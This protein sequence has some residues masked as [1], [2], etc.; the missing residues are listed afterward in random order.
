MINEG[1]K[2]GDPMANLIHS[3]DFE[4]NEVSI[5]L[6]DPSEDMEDLTAVSVEL[7]TSAYVNAR[8]YYENKKKNILK[9]KKTFDASKIAL[10]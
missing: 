6:G 1:K 7:S 5:L 8:N 4:S 3:I 10:K 9:E 2:S